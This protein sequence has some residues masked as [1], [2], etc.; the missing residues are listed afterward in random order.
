MR[1]ATS[2]REGVGASAYAPYPAPSGYRWEFVYE[3]AEQ[4]YEGSE[5]VIELVVI[6]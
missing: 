5:P 6:N 1:S 4:V 3:G 2:R